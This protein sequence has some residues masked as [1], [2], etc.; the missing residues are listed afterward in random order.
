MRLLVFLPVA[1]AGAAASLPAQQTAVQSPDADRA[2]LAVRSVRMAPGLLTLAVGDTAEVSLTFL[3]S[4]GRPVSVP[5]IAFRSGAV[6]ALSEAGRPTIRLVGLRT[7][8]EGTIVSVLRSPSPDA[9]SVRDFQ[10][11]VVVTDKQAERVELGTLPYAPY[12]GS[13]MR[14]EARA[15]TRDARDPHSGLGLD[16]SSSDPS[17]AWV[18]AD[19]TV[20]FLKSGTV[21]ITAARGAAQD[22]RRIEVRPNPVAH[23]VLRLDAQSVRTGDVVRASVQAWARGGQPVRDAKFNLGVTAAAGGGTRG[24]AVVSEDG[25]FVATEPGVY[26]IIAELGGVADHATIE[27]RARGPA[28]AAPGRGGAVTPP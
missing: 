24:G 5:A 20:T 1:L 3:D 8:A 12:A 18:A 17:V 14:L 2:A 26:T 23:V 6:A 4:L 9:P 16:W 27:V 10:L 7:D 19:G 21:T 13:S 25:A 11:P 15:W 22:A 28:N